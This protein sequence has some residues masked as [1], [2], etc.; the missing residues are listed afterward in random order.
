MSDLCGPSEAIYLADTLS[1]KRKVSLEPAS[2]DGTM[3]I[4]CPALF[5]LKIRQVLIW[6]CSQREQ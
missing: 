6:E 1:S 4:F 2:P 3:K 5:E